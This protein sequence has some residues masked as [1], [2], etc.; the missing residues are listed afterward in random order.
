M[1]SW[2]RSLPRRL[3]IVGSAAGGEAPSHSGTR[4]TGERDVLR[5]RKEAQCM[6]VLRGIIKRRQEEIVEVIKEGA[7]RL[8]VT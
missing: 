3:R 4:T 6:E 7:V 1:S 2:S 8:Y 5:E